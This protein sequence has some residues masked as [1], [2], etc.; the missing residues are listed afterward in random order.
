MIR[1]TQILLMCIFSLFC[2]CIVAQTTA[3]SYLIR[4]DSLPAADYHESN[5]NIEISQNSIVFL[6]DGRAV[7]DILKNSI[8]KS[9]E[10]STK[11][12]K[13]CW[14]WTGSFRCCKRNAQ[15]VS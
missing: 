12:Q 1:T 2:S 5:N 10:E 14:I 4:I 8:E 15:K 13:L 9:I 11:P 6:K 7:K 3:P